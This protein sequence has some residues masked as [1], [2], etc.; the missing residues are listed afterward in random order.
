MQVIAELTVARNRE[1]NNYFEFRCD[2]KVVA[3]RGYRGRKT[4]DILPGFLDFL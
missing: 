4:S 2:S 3:H 1:K